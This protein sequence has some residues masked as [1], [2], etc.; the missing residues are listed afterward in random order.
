M[1]LGSRLVSVN[2]RFC[3]SYFDEGRRQSV[4]QKPEKS[5][6]KRLSEDLDEHEAR[7][8]SGFVKL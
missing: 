1:M 6:L 8:D 7:G 5:H 4:I 3:R 2:F